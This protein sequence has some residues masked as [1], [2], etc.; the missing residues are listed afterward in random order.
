MEFA[1]LSLSLAGATAFAFAML[2]PVAAQAA[3]VNTP[4]VKLTPAS[5]ICHKL[6]SARKCSE[7]IAPKN[8][9]TALTIAGIPMDC[10]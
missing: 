3:P 8:P 10:G 9:G 1:Q 5:C 2:M 6:F 7:T 4:A